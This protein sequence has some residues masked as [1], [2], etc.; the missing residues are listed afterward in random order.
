VNLLLKALTDRPG[1]VLA[2]LMLVT[3]LALL[4]LVDF[5][6]KRIRLSVDP[7]VGRLLPADD[8]DRVYYER[9]PW[10]SR[11]PPMTLSAQTAW[12]GSSG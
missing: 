5:H 4:Q 6:G 11:W 10:W 2:G 9:N 1:L 8:P 12:P 7:S 3:A